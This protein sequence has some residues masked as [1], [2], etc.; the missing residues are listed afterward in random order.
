MQDI[1]RNERG[2]PFQFR[3]RHLLLLML[4]PAAL[5]LVIG[6]F[7]AVAGKS[8][9]GVTHQ[10]SNLPVIGPELAHIGITGPLAYRYFRH[11]HGAVYNYYLSGH[12]S[13]T[14]LEEWC[15]KNGLVFTQEE[16]YQGQRLSIDSTL[17]KM[18]AENGRKSETWQG[19]IRQDDYLID[20]DINDKRPSRFQ[21]Y[22]CGVY[23][24]SSGWFAL[25]ILA[26]AHDE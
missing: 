21:P 23:R 19:P 26:S 14:G 22:T 5:T 12:A 25:R 16:C 1:A 11:P 6:F 4:A 10:P 20:W 2:R 18:L 9:T 17:S 15:A 24:P 7:E 8:R 13:K 3:L